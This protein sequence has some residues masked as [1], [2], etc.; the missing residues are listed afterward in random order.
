MADIEDKR[1]E[2]YRYT[3]AS[4]Q[5]IQTYLSSEPE[6]DYGTGDKVTQ[7]EAHMLTMIAD[8]P[9]IVAA[10]IAY[11]WC[12]TNGAIS[13]IIKKLRKKELIQV[14]QDKGNM[15]NLPL[16]VTKKGGK[17]SDAH[18][19][20]DAEKFEETI[21]VLEED[22]TLEEIRLF[23]RVMMSYS[24]AIRDRWKENSDKSAA[25]K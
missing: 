20:Y 23:K 2:Y 4:F 17:L 3:D 22:Y 10:K 1:E 7:T 14:K 19:S 9:G 6:K 13:Q 16:Y 25:K 12:R 24:S 8:N 21:V 18:K 11:Q 5:F 15:K